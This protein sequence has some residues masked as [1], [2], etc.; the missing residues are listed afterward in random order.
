MKKSRIISLLFL[1]TLCFAISVD[2][3]EKEERYQA[4]I[5]S[6]DYVIPSMSFEYEEITK[7][8]VAI[9]KKHNYPYPMHI[10]A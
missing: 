6:E 10:S 1:F 4:F 7:E 8:F 2:A 3:Q 5:I 9:L